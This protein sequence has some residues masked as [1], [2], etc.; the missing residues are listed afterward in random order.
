MKA[1][2]NERRKNKWRTNNGSKGLSYSFIIWM[3]VGPFEKD[4]FS[5]RNLADMMRS[6]DYMF[7]CRD[8]VVQFN[9]GYSRQ[10]LQLYMLYKALLNESGLER[11]S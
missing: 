3:K 1:V 2:L 10:R 6:V 4:T 8:K 5:S 11:T 9:I 7:I